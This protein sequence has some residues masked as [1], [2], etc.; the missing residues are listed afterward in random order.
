LISTTALKIRGFRVELNEVDSNL[1]GQP[2]I[3]EYKTLLQRD[4]GEEPTVVSY[5]VTGR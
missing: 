1:R 3:C 5:V 2:L 4:Q